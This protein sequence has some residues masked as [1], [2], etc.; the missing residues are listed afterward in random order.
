MWRIRAL[1]G[2]ASDNAGG[3]PPQKRSQSPVVT[4]T[5]A[6]KSN[7]SKLPLVQQPVKAPATSAMHEVGAWEVPNRPPP[8]SKQQQQEAAKLAGARR[9]LENQRRHG[10]PRNRS[11]SGDMLMSLNRSCARVPQ[12]VVTGPT[13][14]PGGIADDEVFALEIP[15]KSNKH[16]QESRPFFDDDDERLMEEILDGCP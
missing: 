5:W 10:S 8:M 13:C 12:D 16:D 14:L 1:L 7:P 15:A 4:L 3:S 11:N 6:T 9:H 2:R